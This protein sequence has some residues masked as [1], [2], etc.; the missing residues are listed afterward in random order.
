MLGAQ[1]RVLEKTFRLNRALAIWFQSGKFSRE[2]FFLE[3][4]GG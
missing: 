1:W 2:S 3:E 4:K